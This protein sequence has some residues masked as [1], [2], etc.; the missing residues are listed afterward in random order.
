MKT[1]AVRQPRAASRVSLLPSLTI[2]RDNSADIAL[3]EL[4]KS[5]TPIGCWRIRAALQA[6]GITTSE[7]T[8]G[9]LLCQLDH[10]GLT[11]ALGSKG[12]ILTEKGRRHLAALERAQRRHSYHHDLLQA[13]R[14][15]TIED[16]CDLLIARRAAEAET[17]R[18]AALRATAKDVT[19]I[20]NAVHRHIQKVRV[21][22]EQIDHNRGIHRLI[23]EA[24]RN[25]IL[26]AVVNV[27]LQEE[28]LQEIQS[29]IQHAVDGVVPEDHLLILQA[30][31]DRQPDGAAEAMR[32]HIDRLL[33][34][35]QS[36]RAR[37]R[38]KPIQ[39]TSMEAGTLPP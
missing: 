25:R 23:A 28:Y 5:Q 15:Q 4:G 7:A 6:A 31:K 37:P 11:R 34:V 39:R 33:R 12:R 30:I 8:A 18:L 32:T 38:R 2:L 27:L 21:G 29:H 26:Q 3:K 22:C 16:V 36:Y 17:A 35:V 19:A 20:E 14:A 24:S 1:G 9:R 13:V 10:E